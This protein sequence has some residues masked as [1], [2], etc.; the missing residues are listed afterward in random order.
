[1]PQSP[2]IGRLLVSYGLAAHGLLQVGGCAFCFHPLPSGIEQ[3]LIGDDRPSIL[4]GWGGVALELLE[5]GCKG[6]IVAPLKTPLEIVDDRCNHCA[7]GTCSM[8]DSK[9]KEVR[10]KASASSGPLREP[11][12]WS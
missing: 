8:A 2:Q 6:G 7:R 10:T 1:M 3:V 5:N 9:M 12:P 11:L 4:Q